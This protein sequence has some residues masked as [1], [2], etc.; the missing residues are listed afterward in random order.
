MILL[1]TSIF[2]DHLRNHNPSVIYFESIEGRE[3]IIFSAMT[4]T[5]LIA[6][7]ANDDGLKKEKLLHFLHQ[8]DKKVIDNPT[9]V[10]A[11]DISRMH[12]LRVPDA[13]IA[14]TALINN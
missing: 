10:L 13:I 9:A 5:E 12:G 1:D 8:W 4:E 11:G 6:G 14:A 7:K 2:V 3:D